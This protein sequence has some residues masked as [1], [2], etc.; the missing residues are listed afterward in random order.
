MLQFSFS[1]IKQLIF[2]NKLRLFLVVMKIM[3]TF[4]VKK[5]DANN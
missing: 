5:E 3:L 4:A 2:F 1:F